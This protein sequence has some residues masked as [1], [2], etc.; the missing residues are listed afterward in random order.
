MG[1][2]HIVNKLTNYGSNGKWYCCWCVWII[3]VPLCLMSR[4]AVNPCTIG[5][6]YGVPLS[7]TTKTL[8]PL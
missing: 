7:H 6:I 2:T 5:N 4:P 1:K 8:K 3:I